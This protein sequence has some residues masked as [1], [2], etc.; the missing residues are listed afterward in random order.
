MPAMTP[1]RRHRAPA[2]KAP[3]VTVADYYQHLLTTPSNT[4]QP[5]W[6]GYVDYLRAS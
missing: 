2:T 4:E 1:T 3:E 6:E 5:T